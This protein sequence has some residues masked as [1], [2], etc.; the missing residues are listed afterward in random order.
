MQWGKM[1][2]QEIQLEREWVIISEG[3]CLSVEHL[4]AKHGLV[5]LLYF[6]GMTC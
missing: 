3:A 6:W 2:R 1:E 4:G 5:V